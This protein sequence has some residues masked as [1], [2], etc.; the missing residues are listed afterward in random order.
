MKVFS[1][2]L[3]EKTQKGFFKFKPSMVLLVWKTPKFL[4]SRTVWENPFKIFETFRVTTS[5]L[6]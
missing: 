6:F 2:G 4:V 1:R 3:Y 5:K